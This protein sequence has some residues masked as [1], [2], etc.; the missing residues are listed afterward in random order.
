[1]RNRQ[2]LR[3][4]CGTFFPEWLEEK[5]HVPPPHLT[6]KDLEQWFVDRAKYRWV[7]IGK[8]KNGAIRFRCPQCSGMVMTSAKTWRHRHRR[9]TP[10]P[11]IPYVGPIEDEYCCWGTVTIPVEELDTYQQIPFG[12]PAWKKSYARRVQIENLN[13]IAKDKGGLKNGWCRALGLAAHNLGLLALLAAHNLRQAL[14]HQHRQHPEEENG[15]QPPPTPT[16]APPS[17]PSL[18]GKT[19]RGPPH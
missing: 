1:M 9:A 3:L 6:G 17:T 11:D 5:W 15:Q 13:G 4:N 8:G 12:T 18:N 2:T 7:P 16:V 19:T 10:N 14:K